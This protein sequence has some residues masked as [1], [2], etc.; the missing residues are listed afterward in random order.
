EYE[1][2]IN[3]VTD[4]WTSPNHPA[5]IGLIAHFEVKG[6]P[7]SI[8]LDVVKV[9]KSHNGK[10]LAHAFADILKDYEI[11]HKM[12]SCTCD[13]VSNN[14]TMMEEEDKIIPL[15]SAH[16]LKLFDMKEDKDKANNAN[17]LTEEHELLALEA[18]VNEE[19]RLWAAEHEQDKE[20][21]NMLPEDNL[22]EW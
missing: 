14:D 9:S 18:E 21:G 12:L 4:A 11:E 10:N 7:I 1:G 5:N 13:N 6:V 17:L 20:A 15:Y 16:L 2:R 8:I 3:F 19:E 22:D